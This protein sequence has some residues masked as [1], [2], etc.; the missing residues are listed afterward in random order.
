MAR[1]SNVQTMARVSIMWNARKKVWEI[2]IAGGDGVRSWVWH[3]DAQTSVALDEGTCWLV[4]AAVRE[5]L[6]AQLM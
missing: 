5:A 2:T 4:V 3:V 1:R 6:E